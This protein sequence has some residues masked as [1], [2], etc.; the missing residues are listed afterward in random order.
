M[1]LHILPPLASAAPWQWE[2]MGRAHSRILTSSPTANAPANPQ[3]EMRTPDCHTRV[4][5]IIQ[6]LL[7]AT[8]C[9]I[10][11]PYPPSALFRAAQKDRIRGK[12]A[13]RD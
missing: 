9:N 1:V 5:L 10:A 13:G 4:D 11:H 2:N 8:H 3:S 6:A 12:P 7:A